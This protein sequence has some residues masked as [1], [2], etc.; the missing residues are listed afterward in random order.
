MVSYSKSLILGLN[1]VDSILTDIDSRPKDMEKRLI[2]TL[3]RWQVVA[4][5]IDPESIDTEERYLH[6]FFLRCLEILANEGS[7]LNPAG[8]IGALKCLRKELVR[9]LDDPDNYF[10]ELRVI[11]N[12]DERKY[13]N[14]DI[15]EPLL[16]EASTAE[17]LND[18]SDVEEVQLSE[19]QYLAFR[20]IEL[21]RDPVFVTGAAGTGKS[22][23]L[24]YLKRNS[25]FSK[26]S[27][28][29]CFTGIAALNVGGVTLHS[30]V[31]RFAYPVFW[32]S[33]NEFRSFSSKWS[34]IIS[35][36]DMLILD[37]VSMIRADYVD[38]ID[39]AFRRCRNSNLPFGGVKLVM[40]GDLYQLP[41]FI[42]TSAIDLKYL[43]PKASP[44][45]PS[46]K[47]RKRELVLRNIDY[48]QGYE[49]YLRPQF[50]FAHVFSILRISII[51]LKKVHRQ[52]G[53]EFQDCLNRMRVLEHG[54]DDYRLINSRRV[55]PSESQGK[56]RL[57]GTRKSVQHRNELELGKLPT[58][59]S[60]RVFEAI[61]DNVENSSYVPR[62][63]DIAAP[64]RL[65]LKV[66]ARVMFVR[67]SDLWVNGTL[68]Y[69]NNVTDD[70]VEVQIDG[71]LLV[72]VSR[73]KWDIP[74]TTLTAGGEL[75]V[76][77]KC[78]IWQLPLNLAW[79]MTVHKS[80]GQTLES[81]VI[82]FSEP[83]FEAS[84]AYVALSRLKSLNGLMILG[85][86]EP[87]HFFEHDWRIGQ[88]LCDSYA[89][90]LTPIWKI[91]DDMDL[92]ER[93]ISKIS[94]LEVAEL[95]KLQEMIR[96][97][98]EGSLN[99]ILHSIAV[100]TDNDGFDWLKRIQYLMSQYELNLAQ[101]WLYKFQ[102][103]PLH[104]MYLLE[105]AY[106]DYLGLEMKRPLYM[107][108]ALSG[109][110]YLQGLI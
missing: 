8:R 31:L 1:A 77:S 27:L 24:K 15:T 41:P 66:G 4:A 35:A 30:F 62:E 93:A 90:V 16:N 89:R 98:F 19:E 67:N 5:G 26:N 82:D 47:T 92:L 32:P 94:E 107:K 68:G 51:E 109:A 38:A 63:D 106:L 39:R 71:G 53:G 9:A 80:Q 37:E 73:V 85:N 95:P 58:N 10:G 44:G 49:D 2:K 69:V 64:L 99:E 72:N 48:L 88:F 59:A 97:D 101:I 65:E 42:E 91:L 60:L 14:L 3:S 81:A 76:R 78:S 74:T 46:W 7:A 28:V 36:L 20:E 22:H 21:T 110:H 52:S 105:N 57:F 102:A 108:R 40:F 70:S 33:E 23:L 18:H 104:A 96:N 87:K 83:Y 54:R 75:E 103:H 13:E 17:Y 34:Q 84:Q 6:N 11:T 100:W 55:H 43:G 29:G 61:L 50:F 25:K 56:V 79:A 86:L 12:Q 45:E